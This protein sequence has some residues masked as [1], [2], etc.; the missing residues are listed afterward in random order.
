MQCNHANP[1]EYLWSTRPPTRWTLQYSLVNILKGRTERR[2]L[3]ELNRRGLVSDE[4]I[5]GQAL[6]ALG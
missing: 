1:D 3:T 2:N 4:L 5:N 6:N